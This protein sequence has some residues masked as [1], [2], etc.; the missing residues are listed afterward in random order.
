MKQT[1]WGDP[2][3]DPNAPKI[4]KWGDPIQQQLSLKAPTIKPYQEKVGPI[5]KKPSPTAI[6][7]HFW[8]RY[9]KEVSESPIVKQYVE[10]WP[11]MTGATAAGIGVPMLLNLIPGLA[12][13]PEEYLTVPAGIKIAHF[14]AGVGGAA[15]GAAGA[16]GWQDAARMYMGSEKAPKTLEQAY[17]RQAF[18]ALEEGIAEGAGRLIYGVGQKTL[19]PKA[20]RVI[21][22]APG[23]SDDLAEAAMRIPKE[24]LEKLPPDLRL[25]LRRKTMLPRRTVLP[26]D[27]PAR[28]MGIRSIWRRKP[29]GAILTP[30]QQTIDPKLDLI[31]NMLEG[32]ALGGNRLY[33]IKHEINPRAYK[34][35]MQELSDKFWAEVGGKMSSAEAG[36]LA[37]DSIYGSKYAYQRQ[38]RLLYKH[39]DTLGGKQLRVDLRG[40]K[41]LAAM[42]YNEAVELGGIG[43]SEQIEA[44]TKKIVNWP[45]F[46]DGFMRGHDFRSEILVEGR[47]LQQA[48]GS[49]NPKLS[50][51]IGKIE[52]SVRQQMQKTAR[53]HSKELERAWTIADRYVKHYKTQTGKKAIQSLG[54]LAQETPEKVPGMIFR[55]HGNKTVQLFKNTLDD[56][57]FKAVR[58]A[59]LYDMMQTY[60]DLEG[61]VVG[62]RFIRRFN[63]MGEDTLRTMFGRTHLA[64]I[65]KAIKL[66][67]FVQDPIGRGGGGMLIQL[68]QAGFIVSAV[69]GVPGGEPIKRGTAAVILGPLGAAR[70]FTSPTG[71]KWLTEGFKTPTGTK[72][73][74]IIGTRLFRIARGLE[75]RLPERK[76]SQSLMLSP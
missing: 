75:E 26:K 13:T 23:L 34:Q 20:G 11:Q 17:W 74:V 58:T 6:P 40:P 55:P 41:K 7:T 42:M 32:S 76:K 48:L 49:K 9:K 60:S 36:E 52:A 61:R 1:K 30:G 59:W 3:I 5:A 18:G 31:E 64:D 63:A 10:K 53:S 43:A 21:P 2:I 51:A 19:A 46:A 57:A 54:R 47:K 44:F 56:R 70:I 25:Q 14:I 69:V 66:G 35:F 67:Q 68:T 4:T 24:E 16:I 45:D 37:L 22:G 38:A 71:V 12:Y 29:R 65:R 62:D 15:G 33:D 28:K 72:Q 39:I 73:A 8:E 27:S 50:R